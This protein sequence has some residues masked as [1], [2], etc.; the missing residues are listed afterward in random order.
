MRE[1]KFRAWFNVAPI[2][3]KGRMFYSD[4]E[5]TVSDWFAEVQIEQENATIMQ[6][7]G[8]KDKNGK[9]IY[10]SDILCWLGYEVKDGK[11]VRPKRRLVIGD[12]W[13]ND[14]FHLSNIISN[15][16]TAEIIGNVYENPEL[17]EDAI[18]EEVESSR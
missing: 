7:T 5:S 10:E 8:L 17:L 2:W 16:G 14:C 1:I 6:Y 15:N 4:E 9:E 11:Q 12:H 3:W 13:I 18:R